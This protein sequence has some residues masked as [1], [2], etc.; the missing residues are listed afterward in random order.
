LAQQSGEN[1]ARKLCRHIRRLRTCHSRCSCS[2]PAVVPALAAMFNEPSA[3]RAASEVP[4][5]AAAARCGCTNAACWL[6]LYACSVRIAAGGTQRS[7]LHAGVAAVRASHSRRTSS[8]RCI[9]AGSAAAAAAAAFDAPARHIRRPGALRRD[10]DCPMAQAVFIWLFGRYSL[11]RARNCV[12]PLPTARRSRRRL[13]RECSRAARSTTQ[14]KPP[15]RSRSSL[16]SFPRTGWLACTRC[17]D[18]HRLAG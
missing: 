4:R 18:L 12:L 7:G 17:D 6:R 2:A 15:W 3:A 16:C 5:A 1:T 9:P 11:C 13:S 14:R 8:P 10:A